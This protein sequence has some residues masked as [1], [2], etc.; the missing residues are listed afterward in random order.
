MLAYRL[1]LLY[2]SIDRKKRFEVLPPYPVTSQQIQM[3]VQNNIAY[4]YIYMYCNKHIK[5]KHWWED[6]LESKTTREKCMEMNIRRRS[7]SESKES[8]E[9]QTER[10]ETHEKRE[11]EREKKVQALLAMDA[12]KCG[13]RRPAQK[14]SKFFP[15]SVQQCDVCVLPLHT[16][17]A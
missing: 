15:C 6:H 14:I 9:N 7:C 12:S 3:S 10:R 16:D 13:N 8:C 11:R 17:P 5:K 4:I 2:L 1:P